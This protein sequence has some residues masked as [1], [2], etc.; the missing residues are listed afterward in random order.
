[1]IQL[2]LQQIG[3]AENITPDHLIAGYC[4]KT[5]HT[6]EIGEFSGEEVAQ[7][8]IRDRV[9][10]EVRPVKELKGFSKFHLIPGESRSVAFTLTAKELGFYTSQ[11]EFVVEPGTFDVMVGGNSQEGLTGSFELK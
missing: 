4:N 8:Y 5:N 11:G 7:L 1:M 9:A 6:V 10:S 3:T 2:P